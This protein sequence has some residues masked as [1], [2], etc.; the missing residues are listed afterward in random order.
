[1]P[2]TLIVA[3]LAAA[4]VAFALFPA[5]AGAV[6]LRPIADLDSPTYV[7]APPG[8]HKRLFITQQDGL[9]RVMKK[10]KLIGKPFLNLT[11]LTDAEGERG[12]LSMAFHPDYKKNRRLYTYFTDG[13]SRSS[14]GPEATPRGPR[15]SRAHSSSRCL[16]A[17][18][19]TTTAASCS[20]ARTASCTR[21][22]AM[23]AATPTP[24]TTPRTR[25]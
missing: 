11:G 2:R 10:G 4:A 23:V 3:A 9:I 7:T 14:S 18:P 13:R 15:S 5:G 12:L 20:S 1:M 19:P 25:R 8:D 17:T 6:K 22:P 21:A 24:R 16:T